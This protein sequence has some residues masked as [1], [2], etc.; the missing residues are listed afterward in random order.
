MD[1]QNIMSAVPKE[2][3]VPQQTTV[4]MTETLTIANKNGVRLPIPTAEEWS[5]AGQYAQMLFKNQMVPK[6]LV[7]VGQVQ[8]I[9]LFGRDL[10]LPPIQAL[11]SITFLDG[12]PL[13]YT[14]VKVALVQKGGCKVEWG[15]YINEKGEK[16]KM[17][18]TAKQASVLVTR[19]DGTYDSS[20][21]TWDEV[22]KRGLNMVYGK[23][24]DIWMK[25]PDYMM[26]YHVFNVATR[27][28]CADILNGM[29]SVEQYATEVE[30]SDPQKIK[31]IK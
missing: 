31:V 9:I 26:K 20:S 1:K 15:V 19:T 22:T 3:I 30:V 14:A 18:C 5:I 29:D 6:S 11:Q 8:A 4:S 27:H 25:N 2:T 13:L 23:V 28:L 17:P 7:S 24:K 21:I 16:V 10:G 12:K